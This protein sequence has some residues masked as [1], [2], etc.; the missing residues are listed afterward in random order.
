M[1]RNG[2]LHRPATSALRELVRSSFEQ[3]YA[4]FLL[5]QL[6]SFRKPR[7]MSPRTSLD[8]PVRVYA[9]NTWR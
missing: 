6:I 8:K 3:N 4:N 9:K 1:T 2:G 7:S 5:G